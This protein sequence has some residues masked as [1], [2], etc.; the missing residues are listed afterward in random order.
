MYYIGIDGGG[1]KTAFG[2]FKEDE[3]VDRVE[4][5]TCHFLQVGY[6]AMAKCLKEGIDILVDKH[7]LHDSSIQIGIGM[8]GYGNDEHIR[9]T[10][11]KHIDLYLSHYEYVITSDIHI[12]LLA[13]L[14]G[15]EGILAIGGTGS[16]AMAEVNGELI[17]CGGW[18]YQLGDEGSAYWIG[19]QLLKVF[20]KQADGRLPKDEIYDEFMNYYHIDNPYEIIRIV[21]NFDNHRTSIA[22]M[23]LL[24][25]KLSDSNITCQNILKEAAYE[26]SLLVKRLI[27]CYDDKPLITYHGGLFH[28]AIYKDTFI[29]SLSDYHVVEP[30]KHALYG[31]YYYIKNSK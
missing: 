12:A 20:T 31:A 16:I 5:S 9:N 7:H 13:G 22:D 30:N 3:L 29:E 26:L 2:L 6:E 8:A 1:T 15:H 17:R 24:C 14:N 21:N 23:S 4:L 25:S 19:K 11:K 18:G 10:I 28:N 27:L